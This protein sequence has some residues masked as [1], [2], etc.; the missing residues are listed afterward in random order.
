SQ[1]WANVVITALRDG[2]GRLLSFSKVTRDLTERKRAEEALRQANVE[3]E[4]RVQKRTA[5]LAR[6]NEGVAAESEQRK[7]LDRDVRQRLDQL[8]EADRHKN[9]FLAMLAHELRNPLAPV[10]NALQILKM[11]GADR[12]TAEQARG[13]MERQVGHLVRLVDDLL[14]V[15]RIMQG[16]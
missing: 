15:S 12:F 10:R 7:R 3:S 1:F 9:E 16:R 4:D 2:E 6:A 11:S 5:E 13:L 8:A 14:D